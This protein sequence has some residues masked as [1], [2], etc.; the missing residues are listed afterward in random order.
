MT[1]KNLTES[2]L[3]FLRETHSEFWLLGE[4]FAQ[5]AYDARLAQRNHGIE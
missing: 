2:P 1:E 3:R 5:A 4:I